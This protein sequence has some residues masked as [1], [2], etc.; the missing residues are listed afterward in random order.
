LNKEDPEGTEAEEEIFTAE[1]T[2]GT[3]GK[4]E[5]ERGRERSRLEQGRAVEA[6]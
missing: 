2:E 6:E 1:G 3:E 4:Q 5:G